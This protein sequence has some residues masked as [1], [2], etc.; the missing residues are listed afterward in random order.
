MAQLRYPFTTSAATWRYSC[1]VCG[2]GGRQSCLRCEGTVRKVVRDWRYRDWKKE[3]RRRATRKK[4]VRV[5]GA[6]SRSAWG[7]RGGVVIRT[8]CAGTSARAA[9]KGKVEELEVVAQQEGPRLLS[10]VT[11]HPPQDLQLPATPKSPSCPPGDKQLQRRG[12]TSYNFDFSLGAETSDCHPAEAAWPLTFT[13][14]KPATYIVAS[15]EVEGVCACS[16]KYRSVFFLRYCRKRDHDGMT[17]TKVPVNYRGV[18]PMPQL[19]TQGWVKR[20]R[21]SESLHKELTGYLRS[22][23]R[24]QRH[25][26]LLRELF[27]QALEP[28]GP[29]LVVLL[30]NVLLLV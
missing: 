6:G 14:T 18:V 9:A 21:G 28:K 2:E 27:A 19:T 11:K 10:L 1:V 24:A 22:K 5:G 16:G 8:L 29:S 20:F 15:W 30:L 13:E 26:K 23:V 3:R 12:K 17:V 7:P 25:L 4:R